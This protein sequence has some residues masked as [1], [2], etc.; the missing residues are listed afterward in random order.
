MRKLRF[1]GTACLLLGGCICPLWAETASLVSSLELLGQ[2]D[3][4]YEKRADPAAAA[5]AVALYQKAVAADPGNYPAW[6]HLARACWWWG[7]HA[8]RQARLA[9]FDQGKTA[10]E[11]AVALQPQG[12]DGHYWLGVCMGRTGEERGVLNSLFLVD[13]IAKEMETVLALH[14]HDAEAQHVL[15]ILYRKAPGW[16]LS[17]GDMQKSLSLAREA[18][19]NRPDLIN[20]HVGLALTLMALNQKEEAKKELQLALTLPGAPEYQPESVDDKRETQALL[21][22]LP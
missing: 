6:W 15:S 14:P 21:K 13:P 3:A 2:A 17:R 18:V 7:D 1:W 8:P 20:T 10:G 22:Q 9:L 11:H 4:Q 12:R 5:L 19:A 16:P